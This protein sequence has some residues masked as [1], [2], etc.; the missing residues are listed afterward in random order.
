M[1]GAPEA[2]AVLKALYVVAI[3]NPFCGEF[4]ASGLERKG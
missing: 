1:G 2:T 3:V 4:G